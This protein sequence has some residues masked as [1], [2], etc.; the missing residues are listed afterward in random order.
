MP[1]NDLTSSVSHH[2]IQLVLI[3][4]HQPEKKYLNYYDRAYEHWHDIW[5]T[6]FKERDGITRLHGDD[7][8]RQDEIMTLFWKDTCLAAVCNR[9]IDLDRKAFRNDSYFG[10]WDEDSLNTLGKFGNQV[11]ICSQFSV[12]PKCPK[13]NGDLKIRDALVYLVISHLKRCGF[14]AVTGTARKDKGMQES[15]AKYGA[16]TIKEDLVMHNGYVDLMA[17]FRDGQSRHEPALKNVCDEIWARR[18]GTG[19]VEINSRQQVA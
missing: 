2:E 1:S 17:F 13:L 18:I 19:F 4:G 5:E 3:C 12:I 11:V 9:A 6:H 15:F 16:E 8:T 7:F 14:G 10:V